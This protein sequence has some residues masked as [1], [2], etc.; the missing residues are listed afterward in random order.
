[1]MF[2][3]DPEGELYLDRLTAEQLIE[4]IDD[5][6]FLRARAMVAAYID[7]QQE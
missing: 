7:R 1:M 4:L 2:K 6:R 5:P 3:A